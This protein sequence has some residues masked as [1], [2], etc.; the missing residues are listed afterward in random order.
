MFGS[1]FYGGVSSPFLPW[2]LCALLI[3]FFYLSDRPLLVVGIFVAHLT[4]FC[5]AYVIN[6]AFPE[7][8][9]VAALST[10]GMISVLCATLYSSM[11]ALYYAYVMIE[12]SALRHEI[13]KHLGTAGSFARPS[14]TR[15]WRTRP[16]RCFS[17]R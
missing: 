14:T 6:G 9:P 7:R 8:V 12:Q 5:L 16:R 1:F 10:V 13:E 3:G 15:N 17:P 2:F 11:M 4:G